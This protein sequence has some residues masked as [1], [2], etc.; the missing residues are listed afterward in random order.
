ML[1]KMSFASKNAQQVTTRH[2]NLIAAQN[3]ALLMPIT[4]RLML[5]NELVSTLNPSN[6]PLEPC[7]KYDKIAF[8]VG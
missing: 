7:F 6:L 1:Y 2:C 8:S 5:T 3:L 4:Q